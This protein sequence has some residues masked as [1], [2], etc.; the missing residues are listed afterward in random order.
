[1]LIRRL[2]GV[3]YVCMGYT[4]VEESYASVTDPIRGGLAASRNSDSA[5]ERGSTQNFVLKV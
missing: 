1:M 5:L 4:A 2:Y 3:L